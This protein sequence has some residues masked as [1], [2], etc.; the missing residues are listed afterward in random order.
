MPTVID[1]LV[2]ELGLDPSKFSKGQKEALDRFKKL[3]EEAQKGGKATED[4]ARRVEAA[5]T[6]LKREAVGLIGAFFGGRGIKELVSYLTTFDAAAGRSA[7]TLNMSTAELSRWHGV[8]QQTGGTAEGVTGSLQ[9]LT[10]QVN[11]FMLT[12]EGSFLPVFNALGISLFDANKQ[13]KTAGQ[14]FLDLSRAVQG[15]DPGR[16]RAMLSALGIDGATINALL[17]GHDALV[18]LIADQERLGE[19]TKEDAAAAQ[20]LQKAWNEAEKSATSFGRA[21]VTFLTPALV[22]ALNRTRDVFS[23]L[24]RGYFISPNSILGRALGLKYD[25]K[26]QKII[27]P[28]GVPKDP[29]HQLGFSAGTAIKGL[30]GPAA[31]SPST[32]ASPPATTSGAISASE[33][34]AYIRKAAAARGIDPD[35]AVKVW[36][37]EGRI[38]YVGD[39]GSSFGPF[40]LHYGGVAGGGMAVGGLGDK[41][42]KNTGLD[43]RDPATVRQQIDFALDEARKSGWGAWHGWKGVPYAGINAG[44]IGAPAAAAAAGAGRGG[45]TSTSTSTTTVGTINVNAPKATDATGI[46][47][48]IVPALKRAST[49]AQANYGQ[50]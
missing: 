25:E 4:G 44:A 11:R 2:V 33:T 43:A 26:D 49:A 20:D 17:L 12:G 37:S 30:I 35:V 31:A 45:D 8:A 9:G 21:I 47:E 42:T 15:M 36:S 1:S 22:G 24:R 39:R 48:T 38:G 29:L 18:K 10:D 14:L 19:I 13:L 46:A 5:F 28:D 23:E 50:Q 3:Q 40:Q 34:E 7:K 32:P 27:Y 16:A 6:S 41:F